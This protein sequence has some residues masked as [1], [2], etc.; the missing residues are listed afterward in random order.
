MGAE[1]RRGVVEERRDKMD[2]QMEV[3]YFGFFANVGSLA[4]EIEG[5]VW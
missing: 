2:A 4:F 3:R 1:W 5:A